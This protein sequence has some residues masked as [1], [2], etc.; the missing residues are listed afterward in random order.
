MADLLLGSMSHM[1]APEA[2]LKEWSSYSY[3]KML[4]KDINLSIG[5]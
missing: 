1:S 4:F 3:V 2:E 5:L